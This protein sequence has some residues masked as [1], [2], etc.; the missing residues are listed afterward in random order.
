VKD[1]T[2]SGDVVNTAARLQA[3]AS[4]GEI[5][6]SPDVHDRVAERYPGAVRRTLEVRGSSNPRQVYALSVARDPSAE[7]S[8]P[9]DEPESH[10]SRFERHP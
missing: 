7:A 4:S 10:W 2:R 9:G 1:F 8:V 5:L 6:M 3:S